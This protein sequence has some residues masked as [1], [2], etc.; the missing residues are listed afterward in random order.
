MENGVAP[1]IIAARSARWNSGRFPSI[2]AIASPLRRP[3]ACRP[4]A[5]ASTRSRSSPQVHETSSSL[6]RTAT[7]SARSAD[8]M[9]KA[10]AIVA[11]STPRFAAV[12]LSTPTPSPGDLLH[13]EAIAPKPIDV[14]GEPHGEEQDHQHE[15]Y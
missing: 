5:R 14:V 3:R 8:V 6:V 2:S 7:S 4:A 1:T 9:R 10:S 11:A 15:P 12:L 13:P